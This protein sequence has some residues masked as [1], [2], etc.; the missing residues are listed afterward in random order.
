MMFPIK[1][2]TFEQILGFSIS[3]MY[4][5]SPGPTVKGK[6]YSYENIWFV[7]LVIEWK[8]IIFP[9]DHFFPKKYFFWIVD[10]KIGKDIAEF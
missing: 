10:F 4:Y 9:I 3:E 1:N 2:R 6:H 7:R 5:F 8:Y